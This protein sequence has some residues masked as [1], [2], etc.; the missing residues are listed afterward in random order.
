[1]AA[2]RFMIAHTI[3]SLS[4][5]A[6]SKH[7]IIGSNTGKILLMDL[8]SGQLQKIITEGIKDVKLCLAP[9]CEHILYRLRLVSYSRLTGCDDSLY[10]KN[11]KT[12]AHLWSRH[13]YNR[14]RSFCVTPNLD[15]VAWSLKNKIIVTNLKDKTNSEIDFD[16]LWDIAG[17]VATLDNKYLVSNNMYGTIQITSLHS[18]RMVQK[19]L[20]KALYEAPSYRQ[21][22]KSLS[23]TPDAKY[24]VWCSFKIIYVADLKQGKSLHTIR[25]DPEQFIGSVCVTP[26]GKCAVYN[27]TPRKD[28]ALTPSVRLINLKT[29]K[30]LQN[31][32]L[33]VSQKYLSQVYNDGYGLPNTS[34]DVSPNG[35]VVV[36][37]FEKLI[38]VHPLLLV[39][40][41]YRLWVRVMLRPSSPL[42][43]F[44][45][46]YPGL[47][48]YI[49]HKLLS[50]SA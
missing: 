10:L 32:D 6:D 42:A 17:I 37:S 25:C 38:C 41:L 8:S 7:V 31:I 22:H 34:I 5:T 29:G 2:A 46:L 36:V 50:Y 9:D 48:K 3:K 20:P 43:Q 14:M 24:A 12:K 30:L 44:F 45:T 35:K 1:M 28:A 11:L 39:Q 15:Y 18:L 49:G 16:S 27:V 19:I 23:V 4:V 40:R 13:G 47:L 21:D 33:Q 26:N